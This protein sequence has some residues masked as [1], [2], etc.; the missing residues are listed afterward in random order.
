MSMN[1]DKCKERYQSDAEFHR[2]VEMFYNLMFENKLSLAE[3]KDALCFAGLKFQ[4][5]NTRLNIVYK[6]D[7]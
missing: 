4:M 3:L 5:E 1:F 7:K 2:M 6:D